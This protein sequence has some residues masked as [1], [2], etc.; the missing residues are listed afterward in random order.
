MMLRADEA[1]GV[2]THVRQL[3]RQL[4]RAGGSVP[5]CTAFSWGGPLK[6]PVFGLRLVIKRLSPA[7]GVAW[8]VYW[9]ELFL[10][11]AVRRYLASAGPCVVYAQG[12]SEARAALRARR[13]PHQRVVMAV[14]FRVS[15]AD[16]WCNSAQGRIKRDGLVFRWIRR[17]EREAITRADGL[18]YVTNWARQA[19]LTWLPEAARTPGAVIGNFVS[20][21]QAR[22]DPDGERPDGERPEVQRADGERPEA[23]RPDGEGREGERPDGAARP[24]PEVRDLVSTGALDIMK[25]H[26][27]LLE[28]LAEA[29]KLGRSLTLDVF[30]DGPLREELQDKARSLAVDG[31]VRFRGFRRDVRESL[32][33]YRLYVHSSFNETS[34]LAIMEAMCAG[35]PSVAAPA[36]GIR[37]VLQDGV[38]GRYWDLDDPAGA[39]RTLIELLDDEAAYRGAAQAARDRFSQEFDANVVVPRLT[40]FLRGTTEPDAPW[41]VPSDAESNAES[42]AGFSIDSRLR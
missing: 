5:V 41:L 38:Q 42:A 20:P 7:A 6:Y 39:A 12:P 13:G 30:G 11:Q 19:L 34:S 21:L 40:A 36:G 29:N 33:G 15:L 3:R 1:S 17:R 32:P 4:E 25:N 27:F 26:G 23:G 16:E 10:Q 24:E 9:H 35:L 22:P 2:A 28:V 18:M 31:Q 37:E 8:H 14:H